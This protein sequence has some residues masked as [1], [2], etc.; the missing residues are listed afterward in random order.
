[1]KLSKKWTIVLITAVLV[2]LIRISLPYAILHYVNSTIKDIPKY[3]GH[4]KDIDLSILAG[5][6]SIQNVEIVWLKEKEWVQV[7]DIPS[8]EIKIL[9][10]KL[11]K[12]KLV[13]SA[14]INHPSLTIY[15]RMLL[16][17]RPKAK[18]KAITEVFRE[19]SPV[20]IDLFTVKD[21][22]I[23]Y[24][25]YYTEPNYVLYADSIN[26][27]IRN[28]TNMQRLSSPTYATMAITGKILGSGDL[29]LQL[30]FNPIQTPPN[31]FV[32][33]K[34]MHLD[35]TSL[36]TFSRAQGGFDFEKGTM[37]LVTE[38]TMKD[39]KINGYVK[40]FFRDLQVFSWKK[41]VKEKKKDALKLFWE[42]ILGATTEI[43]KNQKHDQL[44]TRIPI[45]GTIDDPNVD[46]ITAVTNVLR[47]AFVRA[48]IPTLE[49]NVKPPNK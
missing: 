32:A 21:A 17:T 43:F 19:L 1:M 18:K 11:F 41:D 42:G 39:Q 35:V 30:L 3:S 47:D 14:N 27:A 31:F 20:Y 46:M 12:G 33:M 5:K 34:L 13:A 16:P 2:I 25:N 15:E 36:D 48:F 4:V 10:G 23:R 44:A 29:S 28:I 7:L 6:Y 8:I 38:I 26:V 49:G 45:S 22:Q 40:P 37:D 9:W 24:R